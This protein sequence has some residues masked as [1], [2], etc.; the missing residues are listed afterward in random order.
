MSQKL[1]TRDQLTSSPEELSTWALVPYEICQEP[2]ALYQ[3]FAQDIL[4][5]IKE[6]NQKKEKTKLILPVGPKG[7]YPYLVEM[8]NNQ[9][10][11]LKNTYIFLMDEYLDWQGRMVAESDPLSF[12]GY[13]QRE[14]L[15]HIHEE[16][17]P[18]LE[19]L[20]C[21]DPL[22]IDGYSKAIKDLGGLDACFGGIGSHGHVAFNEPPNRNL[23]RVS[24][25][26]FKN[27]LTRVVPLLPE[28]IVLNS[29]RGNGGFYGDF[30][31]MAITVGMKDILSAP[32]I[33]LYCEGGAWQRYV[34]RVALLGAE[35]LDYPVTLLQSHGD[36]KI[37]SDR[38]T[39][40]PPVEA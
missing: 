12:R 33:R 20:F 15:A 18:N 14:V 1:L 16:L 35:T 40:L 10:I 2:I 28:T 13:F 30:P 8:I 4:D 37:Y 34:L 29:I 25:T 17:R 39:A 23:G 22:D 5:I 9:G 26:E 36:I 6:K 19:Q 24:L 3:R 32:K 31:F 11:S 38:A 27:S 21:P 7:Q